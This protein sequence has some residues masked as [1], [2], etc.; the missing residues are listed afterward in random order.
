MELDYVKIGMRIK[1]I[2]KTR[3]M[4]QKYLGEQTGLTTTQIGNIE[5]GRSRPSVDSLADI[6]SVLQI[7]TD[8]LLF[9]C[10]K[11]GHDRYY[12]EY[13]DLLIDCNDADK[14]I[15][16]ETLKTLRNELHKGH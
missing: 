7:A 8:E 13:S 11:Y 14:R 16:I 4:T 9:G 6:S 1:N 2:R 5:T 15:I 3:N 12:E 10:I